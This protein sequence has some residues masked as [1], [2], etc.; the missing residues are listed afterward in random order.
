MNLIARLD[1]DSREDLREGVRRMR[2]VSRMLPLPDDTKFRLYR[3]RTRRGWHVEIYSTLR[4]RSAEIVA[5]QALLNSDF[6]REAFNLFR[7]HQ[8]PLAPRFWQNMPNWNILHREKIPH[9][10]AT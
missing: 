3:F 7:A 9:D 5:L 10:E 2:V 4:L 8:L 1:Y 6:R